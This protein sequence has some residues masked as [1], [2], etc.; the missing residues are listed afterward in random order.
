MTKNKIL[1]KENWYIA[2][3]FIVLGLIFV[4]YKQ[5]V[6][7][8]YIYLHWDEG[9]YGYIAQEIIRGKVPIIEAIEVKTP[10]NYYFYTIPLLIWGF[11]TV[12]GFRITASILWFL[13]I[14]LVFLITRHFLPDKKLAPYASSFMF[15]LFSL[16]N[17]ALTYMLSNEL[18]SQVFFLLSI[19]FL[20]RNN[21]ENKKL[22]N[23]CMFASGLFWMISVLIR[24]TL[25]L[26]AVLYLVYFIFNQKKDD[27]VHFR[28][29]YV[30]RILL[31][32]SGCAVALVFVFYLIKFENIREIFRLLYT[33]SVIHSKSSLEG[34]SLSGVGQLFIQLFRENQLSIILPFVGF[35]CILFNKKA[36]TFTKYFLTAWLAV[37]FLSILAT[38]CYLSRNLIQIMPLLAITSGI[39][40]STLYDRRDKI[41]KAYVFG[42]LLFILIGLSLYI[43]KINKVY[44]HNSTTY[45]DMYAEK[46]HKLFVDSNLIGSYIE[47]NTLPEDKI[48]V[49]GINWQILYLSKRESVTRHIS[50]NL[51]LRSGVSY[52]L[53]NHGKEFWL[54]SQREIIA[55][56][57]REKPEF[58]IISA[59]LI[60]LDL[61]EC[62]IRDEL[63]NLLAEN[64][65][66]D[67]CAI[68]NCLSNVIILKKKA[69]ATTQQ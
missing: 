12:T 6:I 10:L 66:Y 63:L 1:S 23:F 57:T 17:Y 8:K 48:F 34:Y 51:I 38:T 47:M 43:T 52:T 24:H 16:S 46:N 2:A 13:S 3:F 64:Y 50:T 37:A 60:E 18:I 14:F 36:G 45:E 26:T 9:L 54:D 44:F 65:Y 49:W 27:Y 53:H 42:F 25:L 28:R 32:F 56:L 7:Q 35:M 30:Y 21:R 15:F 39:A 29:E 22:T 33:L 20:I 55:D 5:S 31:F 69:K 19:Y 4:I 67:E 41:P 40:I 68:K 62:Y 58:I 61:K 59:P 11:N